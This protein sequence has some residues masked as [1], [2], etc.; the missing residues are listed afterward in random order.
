MHI[1]S[2]SKIEVDKRYADQKRSI[3]VD[4]WIRYR[5]L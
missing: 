5:D 3:P 4:L 1:T 2:A